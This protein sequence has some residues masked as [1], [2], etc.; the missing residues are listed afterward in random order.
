MRDKIKLESTAGTGHF[1]TTT[2]NK[3]TMPGKM[4][5]KKFDPV[6]R[7]HVVYKETKLKYQSAVSGGTKKP[8]ALVLGGFFTSIWGRTGRAGGEAEVRLFC[9]DCAHRQA[10][11]LPRFGLVSQRAEQIRGMVACNQRNALVIMA[12][13]AQLAYWCLCVQQALRGK[14]AECQNQLG[15]HQRDLLRQKRLARRNFIGLRVAIARR[16]AFQHI[17]NIHIRGGV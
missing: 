11:V 17:G 2:K 4:E 6:I 16:A 15:L 8:P 1:Y 9:R 5:I 12:L 13:P 14:A 7:K 10:K 3:R